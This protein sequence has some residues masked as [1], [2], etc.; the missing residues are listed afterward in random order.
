MGGPPAGGR[1]PVGQQRCWRSSLGFAG[2]TWQWQKAEAAEKSAVAAEKQA[3]TEKAV[4]DA[5]NHFLLDDL[6][7]TA[8]PEKQ[9]GRKITVDEVLQNASARID[10][11]FADQPE[12][13]AAVRI[14][15][16][17]SY[18]KLGEYGLAERHLAAGVDLF[19]KSR[20]NTDRGTLS[21]MSDRGLLLA[22]ERKWAEAIPLLRKVVADSRE[23][24]GPDDPLTIEATGRLALVLQD[25]GDLT[26][27]ESL[28][29]ETLPAARRILGPNDPRTLTILN[30]FGILLQA[31]K[32]LSEAE[33]AFRSAADGRAKSLSQSHPDT[34]ES[35]SNLAVVLKDQGRWKEARP[36]Y[37]R[38]LAEEVRILPPD[39]IDTLSTKN[40]LANVLRDLGEWD[41]ALQKY[42]EAYEGFRRVLGPE[43][44]E[45]LRLQSSLG[46]FYFFVG[47]RSKRP[48][49]RTRGITI[50]NA[51]LAIRR[52]G[53]PADHPD[54]LQTAHDLGFALIVQ[55]ELGEAEP[56]V[57]TTLAGR[58]KALG[59]ATATR[60]K[61]R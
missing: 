38:V 6:L 44:P 26:E 14:V 1:G 55:N 53:L 23:K 36:L 13:A 11:R 15:L 59:P 9:L 33:G 25:H 40:N 50:L 5:V 10:G 56:L 45:T 32:K 24:R 35:L 34:L 61:P 18:R 31:R 12:V 54:T 8:T 2:V 28:F 16:G 30:S 21:A 4:S 48:D 41:E 49:L 22:D 47:Q 57:K 29:R 39:H 60:W 37:E 43:N 19:R 27:A 17:N 20:G 58:Q 46:A 52:R 42:D 3:L 7:A 51:V